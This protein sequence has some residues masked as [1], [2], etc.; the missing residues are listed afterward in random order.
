MKTTIKFLALGLMFVAFG[1][2]TATSTFAQT[3]PEECKAIYDKFLIDRKGP[4]L[5]KYEAAV[6]GGKDYLA[7]CNDPDNKDVFDYVTKQ[8][9]RA[10]AK[11]QELKDERDIYKP[12]NDSIPA[13]DWDKA[14][15]LGKVIIA[16]NPDFL[17]VMLVLASIGFDKSTENPAVDK[18]NADTI[19]MARMALAKMEEG[20]PSGTGN[21]G[22]FVYNYKTTA[23]ADGKTNATG[24]MN[25]TIGSITY[26]RLKN[27]KDALPYL[28]KATQVGCETK[29]FSDIYRMI[30]AWYLDEAIKINTSRLEKIKAAGDEDTDETKAMLGMQKGYTERALDAYGRAYKIAT[31]PGSKADA[32]YKTAIYTKITELYKFRFDGKTDGIDKFVADSV[33]KPFPDPASA[34]TPVIEVAPAPTTTPA[35]AMVPTSSTTTGAPAADTRPRTAT[36]TPAPTTTA[37]KPAVTTTPAAAKTA[38]PAATT[39]ADTTSAS[40]TPAT[41]KPVSK[42]KGTR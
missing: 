3:T 7:K 12:F 41:K 14:F 6:A 21:Y 20:K 5:A 1:A 42:K 33:A 18:F 25:F 34:V 17:D 19:N 15:S 10:E 32:A 11:V 28:Y 2:I 37:A 36:A 35:T 38:T 9:P 39:S 40:K 24:W 16:K 27:Q 13:K 31:A 23:C 4:E 22:A 30:G 8:I 26:Y 29:S